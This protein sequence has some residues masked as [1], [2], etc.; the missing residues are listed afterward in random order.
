M[1]QVGDSLRQVGDPLRLSADLYFP[2]ADRAFL[3]I[4]SNGL[5]IKTRLHV[6]ADG[7]RLVADGVA[8]LRPA[9]RKQPSRSHSLP[10]QGDA[11]PGKS[12]PNRH[13]TPAVAF[14]DMIL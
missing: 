7:F 3:P 11:Q 1:R 2:Y 10:A 6:A 9:S 5:V 12:M 4:P 13:D 8:W 14:L